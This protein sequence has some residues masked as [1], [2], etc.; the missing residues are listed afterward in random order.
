M[1]LLKTLK[2]KLKMDPVIYDLYHSPF[3]PIL[4]DTEEDIDRWERENEYNP[5]E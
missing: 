2:S 3:S 1:S 4:D 5:D